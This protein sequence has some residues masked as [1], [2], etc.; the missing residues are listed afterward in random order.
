VRAWREATGYCRE[1]LAALAEQA[2]ITA[3]ASTI[4]RY[5]QREGLVRPTPRHRRPR[6]QNGKAMRPSNGPGLGYLQMDIKHI[7]ARTLRAVLHLLR[8]RG[9]RTS[10]PATK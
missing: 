8:V 7:V 6:F 1:K 2:G 3:S 9:Y 10:L 5:L 4:H